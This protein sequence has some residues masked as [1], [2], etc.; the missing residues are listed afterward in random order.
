MASFWELMKNKNERQAILILASVCLAI[1]GVVVA[2]APRVQ[3]FLLRI[4]TG[5]MG[6]VYLLAAGVLLTVWFL[7][8]GFRG[9]T[10]RYAL[11]ILLF[12][13]VCIWLVIN[14]DLVWDSMVHTIGLWPTILIVL[15]GAIGAWLVIK[16][17]L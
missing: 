15:F 13:I 12:T 1:V 8:L 7:F 9:K 5:G 2:C 16:V 10:L 6:L 3:E 17:L 14:F 11:I 4:L